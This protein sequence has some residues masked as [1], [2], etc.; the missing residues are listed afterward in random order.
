MAARVSAVFG[1]NCTAVVSSYRCFSRRQISDG[2]GAEVCVY[3]ENRMG[4]LEC[5]VQRLM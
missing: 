3:S 5:L 4:K 2:L 1:D